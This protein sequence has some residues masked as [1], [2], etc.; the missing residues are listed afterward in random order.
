MKNNLC[1]ICGDNA[2]FVHDKTNEKLCAQCF[3]KAFPEIKKLFDECNKKAF[4]GIGI[5]GA[6]YS[7]R[8]L[9]YWSQYLSLPEP[10][11]YEASREEKINPFHPNG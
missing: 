11:I 10:R 8:Q 1:N 4:M 3:K 5:P 7:K 6:Y 9:G 2:K